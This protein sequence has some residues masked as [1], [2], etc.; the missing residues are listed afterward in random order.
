MHCFSCEVSK[1]HPGHRRW[2]R[3][4]CCL[5]DLMMSEYSSRLSLFVFFLKVACS[6]FVVFVSVARRQAG[7]LASALMV[8]RFGTPNGVRFEG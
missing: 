8:C 1:H 3:F 5:E 7:Y 2:S 4:Q 6:S